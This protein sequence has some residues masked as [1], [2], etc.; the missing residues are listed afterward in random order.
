MRKSLAY[1]RLSDFSITAIPIS[2]PFLRKIKYENALL[3]LYYLNTCNGLLCC[4]ANV[5]N[6]AYAS[7]YAEPE[8]IFALYNA[9][10]SIKT[11]DFCT[12]ICYSI[13]SIL[14]EG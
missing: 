2:H 7:N 11:V 14:E 1:Q 12:N 3:R 13:L 10:L 4:I 8:I 6:A 5:E 9:I